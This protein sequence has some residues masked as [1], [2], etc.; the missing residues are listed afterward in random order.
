MSDNA[1]GTTA[2][3]LVPDAPQTPVQSQTE[4]WAPSALSGLIAL[5]LLVT[6]LFA[7]VFNLRRD[8]DENG[9]KIEGHTA[10]LDALEKG[11]MAKTERL[12]RTEETTKHILEG[13]ARMETKLDRILE[14]YLPKK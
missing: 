6:G 3:T 11:D 2:Q 8:T 5:A 7:W 1:S 4:F 12:V 13:Q 14:S 10:R 9:R